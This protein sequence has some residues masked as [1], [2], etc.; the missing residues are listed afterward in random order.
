ML[1]LN[2]N[3]FKTYRKV[4]SS[5]SPK[6]SPNRRGFWSKNGIIKPITGMKKKTALLITVW[7]NRALVLVRT[8]D[9]F[10]ILITTTFLNIRH[11]EN[12]CCTLIE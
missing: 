8:V 6:I 10:F 7:K 11:T 12:N 9:F 5:R 4:N 1:K 3:F 2:L